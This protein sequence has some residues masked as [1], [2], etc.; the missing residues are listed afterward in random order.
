MSRRGFTLF[1]V[2]IAL[3]IVTI[4]LS[5]L[6]TTINVAFR[7][8]RAAEEAVD[9]VRDTQTVGDIFVA[10]VACA[11]PPNPQSASADSIAYQVDAT[12]QAAAAADAGTTDANVV[13]SGG[14][15]GLGNSSGITSGTYYLF[16]PFIGD[17]LSLTFFT[18]GPEP[19]AAIQGDVRYVE[20]T[21]AQQSDGRLG[22]VRHVDTNLLSDQLGTD[23]AEEILV[24]G[25]TSVTY[26]YFDGTNWL[27]AWNSTDPGTN[28]TLPKAVKMVLELEPAHAGGPAREIVRTATVW[29][30][31]KTMNDSN[32]AVAASQAAAT[33]T[34]TGN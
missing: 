33:Q 24:T 17:N 21:L 34:T 19:K 12:Q 9:A 22:L 10:D 14:I 32:N 4:L 26:Q 3:A 18:T 11:V 27:G 23:M 6:S 13:A 28:N 30:A 31:Q 1:E 16:G 2:V 20:Y 15:T 7:Q 8:K 5:T 25:V 29:C